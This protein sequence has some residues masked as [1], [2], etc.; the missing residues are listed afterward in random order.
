MLDSPADASV[1]LLDVPGSVEAGR[2]VSGTLAQRSTESTQQAELQDLLDVLSG[3]RA[4][5]P[6]GSLYRLNQNR[7]SGGTLES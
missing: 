2:Q 3:G 5:A 1:K 6:V 4:A 7:P